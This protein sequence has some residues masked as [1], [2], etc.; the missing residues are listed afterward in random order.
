MQ[1]I[2]IRQVLQ[3]LPANLHDPVAYSLLPARKLLPHTVLAEQRD[4]NEL[5]EEGVLSLPLGQRCEARLQSR[6]VRK[7]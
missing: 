1:A 5:P 3:E 7:A 4:G 2:I 6:A